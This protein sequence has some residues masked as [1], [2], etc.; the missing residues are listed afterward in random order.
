MVLFPAM[1]DYSF[2]G[3]GLEYLY[4]IVLEAED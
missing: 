3:I 4:L 1:E 2:I